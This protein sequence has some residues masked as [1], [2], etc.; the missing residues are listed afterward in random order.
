M[1]VRL[2]LSAVFPAEC[3]TSSCWDPNYIIQQ[4]SRLDRQR[5][6][7]IIRILEVLYAA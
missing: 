7:V 5:R 4:L 1:F 3:N 2:L 6:R